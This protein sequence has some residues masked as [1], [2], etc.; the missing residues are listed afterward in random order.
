MSKHLITAAIWATV[1]TCGADAIAQ[2]AGQDQ[3][4]NRK[5]SAF[6]NP[7]DSPDLPNVL[8]I[9]DSI[10]IGYTPYVRRLLQGKADVYRIRGNGK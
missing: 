3:P 5:R 2:D 6:A 9:G 8:L 1:A 7:K 10:S 4:K